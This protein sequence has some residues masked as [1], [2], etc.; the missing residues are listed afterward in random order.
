MKHTSCLVVMVISLLIFCCCM[1]NASPIVKLFRNH[2][3]KEISLEGFPIVLSESD[4]VAYRDFR[5]KYP[6]V[7]IN[8]ID[9][10]CG[11]CVFKIR[12]WYKYYNSLPMYEN[13]AYVFVFRGKD[14]RKFLKNRIGKY[15]E[16]PFYFFSSEDFIY[17]TNN[18]EI[19]RQI[20]DGGF[21]LDSRNHIRVIGS[22]LESHPLRKMIE[23]VLTKEY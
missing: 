8:Y 3:G 16:A 10:E 19:D 5:K 9:E 21:L 11:S 6:Y 15:S 23:K 2:M 12:E 18:S 14:Y 4:T 7:Y 1:D 13:L 17:I 22:P 20:I